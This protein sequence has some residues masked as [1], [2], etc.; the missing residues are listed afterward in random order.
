MCTGGVSGCMCD[1]VFVHVEIRGHPVGI[2]P[3]YYVG[4]RDWT[5][6][7][8]LGDKSL[9]PPK[10]TLEFSKHVHIPYSTRLKEL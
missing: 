2:T 6:I 4:P 10:K 1:V 7:R 3:F 8:R 9:C 5:Q